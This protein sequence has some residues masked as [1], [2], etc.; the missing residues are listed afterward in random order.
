M[1]SVPDAILLCGGAGTRLKSVTGSAPKSLATIGNRPFLDLLLHQLRRHDFQRVILAVGYQKEL[2]RSYLGDRS[3]GLTLEYSI[4]SVPLGTGGA[5]RNA[6]DLIASDSVL[7][8]NGDSYTDADLSAFERDFQAANADLS[9]LVVP[10]DGRVDCGLVSV[11]SR[12]SVLGFKEKQT[13]SGNFHINAGIYMATKNILRDVPPGV[14]IS[15]EEELFPRW[16]A[17]RK[18]L[19]AFSYPGNCVDIGTPERYQ[20]AQDI[21]ANAEISGPPSNSEGLRP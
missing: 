1:P 8:M 16:L 21:L 15:L 11:D 18:S 7:I 12:G 17:E 10:A 2:I 20:R 19:R 9:V 5:L 13:S 14:R 3:N 4:E 6:V